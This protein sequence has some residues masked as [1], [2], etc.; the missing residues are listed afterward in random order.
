[1]AL[2]GNYPI[3]QLPLK[4]Q[5]EA[6]T[7]EQVS[8]V[9]GVA[10]RT[11]TTP[12]DFTALTFTPGNI[13]VVVNPSMMTPGNLLDALNNAGVTADLDNFGRLVL[14]DATAVSGNANLKTALGLA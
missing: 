10:N 3:Q 2:Y 6:A 8:G 11:I 12:P 5:A 4:P 13:A 14:P 9:G 7:Q 1:M